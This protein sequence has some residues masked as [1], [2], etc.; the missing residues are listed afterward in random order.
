MQAF[1]A[2]I[3]IA[4]K[5][6]LCFNLA[7]KNETKVIDRVIDHFGN[8]YQAS[9]ALNIKHQQFY[10]WIAKGYIPFKRGYDIE[11]AT[12]GAIKASE[13]WEDAGKAAILKG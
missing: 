2:K 11:K 5:I 3:F 10:S 7:M 8:A 9:I 12:G 6:K 13:I 4:I 1:V